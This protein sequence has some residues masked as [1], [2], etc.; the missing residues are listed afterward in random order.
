MI[1]SASRLKLFLKCP[2]A[3]KLKYVDGNPDE[4]GEP[5]H[6]G[7][8]VHEMIEDHQS[9]RPFKNGSGP[10]FMEAADLF[11][12][13]KK[14]FWD[15]L[16]PQ[17]VLAQEAEYRCKVGKHEVVVIMDDVR[18]V[19]G[20]LT[21]TDWKTTQ[22]MMTAQEMKQDPQVRLYCIAALKQFPNYGE[23]VFRIGAIRQGIYEFVE[24]EKS[25]VDEWEKSVESL[26][27][28][29]DTHVNTTD[30]SRF[31]YKPGSGCEWC[32]F[33]GVCSEGK[34]AV[35]ATKP[36]TKSDSAL[37]AAERILLLERHLKEAKKELKAWCEAKGSVTANDVV[38]GFWPTV[39]KWVDTGMLATDEF[40]TLRDK[41]EP[42]MALD[43]TSKSK[44]WEDEALVRELKKANAIKENGGT[45][46]DARKLKED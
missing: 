19:G 36:I 33:F 4:S 16:D 39:K 40:K 34:K 24:V 2:A 7:Q 29:V 46:F 12:R 6:I 22:R 31:P 27:T 25:E 42:F 35:K 37:A 44:L 1:Y 26:I 8:M 15:E 17:D 30:E 20:F 10:E 13:W 32:S 28:L 3:F 23:V 21:I 11:E 18:D 41:L 43:D 9:G 38:F 45:K 5:A 14:K